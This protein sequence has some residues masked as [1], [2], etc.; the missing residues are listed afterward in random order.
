MLN[1]TSNI[2]HKISGTIDNVKLRNATLYKIDK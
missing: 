2:K 1:C